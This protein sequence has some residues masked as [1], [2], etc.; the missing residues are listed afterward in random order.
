VIYFTK[1]Q[2]IGMENDLIACLGI[3]QGV[4]QNLFRLP[5]YGTVLLGKNCLDLPKCL[6][7]NALRAWHSDCYCPCMPHPIHQT[8]MK[9]QPREGDKAIFATS[10]L[11]VVGCGF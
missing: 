10:S 6:Q 5:Y 11:M 1:F 4:S 2:M 7:F 8:T 3:G 9:N